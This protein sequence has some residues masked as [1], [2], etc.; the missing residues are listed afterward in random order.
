M[1]L[2]NVDQDQLNMSGDRAHRR[3]ENEKR[4]KNALTVGRNVMEHYASQKIKV[5][6]RTLSKKFYHRYLFYSIKSFL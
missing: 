1:K 4:R 5:K 3:C 2:I 6:E